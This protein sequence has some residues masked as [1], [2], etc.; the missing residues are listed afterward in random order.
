VQTAAQP[1]AVAE[2]AAV[3]TETAVEIAAVETAAAETAAVQM[4]AVQ[5]ASVATASVV[6]AA[7]GM[8]RHGGS[9]GRPAHRG[10]R[11][12]AERRGGDG[13]AGRDGCATRHRRQQHRNACRDSHP[14]S[15]GG[16]G[17]FDGG[18]AHHLADRMPKSGTF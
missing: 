2:T 16:T 14:S 6:T 17:R 4:A 12:S 9:G 5:T 10:R 3:E 13:S 8:V 18:V 11:V 15:H 7:V 1:T